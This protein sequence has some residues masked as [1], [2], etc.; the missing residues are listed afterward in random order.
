VPIQ[1]DVLIKSSS[2]SKSFKSTLKDCR[3]RQGG[4]RSDDLTLSQRN[5][6]AVAQPWRDKC[7]KL[8]IISAFLR[9]AK[10]IYLFVLTKFRTQ[11]R[12]PLL[13]EFL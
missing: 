7:A 4:N 12:F 3:L 10:M 11:N 6:E 8:Q 2:L 1:I 5:Q 9:K 13:L